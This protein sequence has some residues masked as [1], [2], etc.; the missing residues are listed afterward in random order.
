MIS[1]TRQCY[2]ERLEDLFDLLNATT[3]YVK[4]Q[5]FPEHSLSLMV[6]DH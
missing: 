5:F 2:P 1:A 4:H 3:R 6:L